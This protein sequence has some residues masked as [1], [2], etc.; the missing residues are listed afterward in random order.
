MPYIINIFNIK[1]GGIVQNGNIDVGGVVQNSHTANSKFVGA[2]ISQGDLSPSSSFM[3]NG[4]NDCDLTDQDQIL[5]PS[6]P[7]GNQF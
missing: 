6:Q 1:T 4:Y 2:N 5:N 7:V 3:G